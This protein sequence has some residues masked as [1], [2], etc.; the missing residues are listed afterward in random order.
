MIE[1]IEEFANVNIDEEFF[2]E[3][4]ENVELV[5]DSQDFLNVVGGKEIIQLKT[6]TFQRV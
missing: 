4:Y 6:I 2:Y 1:M 3:K 5:P